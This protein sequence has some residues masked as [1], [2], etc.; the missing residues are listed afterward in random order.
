MRH[1]KLSF[2]FISLLVIFTREAFATVDIDDLSITKDA[3]DHK[4]KTSFDE[5]ESKKLKIDPIR[6]DDMPINPGK[7]FRVLKQIYAPF[8]GQSKLHYVFKSHLK[9]LGAVLQKNFYDASNYVSQGEDDEKE[10]M[11]AF[12][13]LK[14]SFTKDDLANFLNIPNLDEKIISFPGYF[15]VMK[16]FFPA[17]LAK[18]RNLPNIISE[19]CKK[20]IDFRRAEN[21]S[22]RFQEEIYL[23]YL[24]ASIDQEGLCMR[25]INLV[26]AK[27]NIMLA[28]HVNRPH[29]SHFA[30]KL[31]SMGEENEALLKDLQLNND[32]F[33][34]YTLG[35]FY[36]S[37][38][39]YQESYKYYRLSALAGN[40]EALASLAEF[41][42]HGYTGIEDLEMAVN[43]TELASNY[44]SEKAK[45]N[46][47]QWFPTH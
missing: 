18:K 27:H 36:F 40:I 14:I 6:L 10:A 37:K 12:Y 21:R 15:D 35:K 11:L 47:V 41:Y 39:N 46:M 45:A 5:S 4:R 28:M 19:R 25:S 20:I 34:H 2:L 24:Y 43:L 7:D 44:G 29:F 42:K 22:Q 1:F 31:I 9:S 3:V 38:N 16:K 8:N 17:D 33:G 26:A 13:N 32:S 23:I 30:A